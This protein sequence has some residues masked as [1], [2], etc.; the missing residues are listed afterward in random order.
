ML[1]Q[2]IIIIEQGCEFKCEQNPHF[3]LV[4]I[5]ASRMS[6]VF[7][8]DV[9]VGSAMKHLISKSEIYAKMLDEHKK[10]LDYFN[11]LILI[12][13]LFFA[14]LFFIRQHRKMQKQM[15]VKSFC[16]QA[17]EV[18]KTLNEILSNPQSYVCETC[19][20][21]PGLAVFAIFIFWSLVE[22]MIPEGTG[23]CVGEWWGNTAYWIHTVVITG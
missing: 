19:V 7:C 15:N 22:N 14:T 12:G 1:F 4:L 6:G 18:T 20:T 5:P 13:N 21:N 17:G 11:L 16:E 9:I 8:W 2:I 10:H 23:F 3:M